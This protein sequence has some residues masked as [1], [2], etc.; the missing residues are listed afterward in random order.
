MLIVNGVTS[1]SINGALADCC[2]ARDGFGAGGTSGQSAAG[3]DRAIGSKRSGAAGL[4][5]A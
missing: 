5:N 2:C 4:S 1:R 3:A